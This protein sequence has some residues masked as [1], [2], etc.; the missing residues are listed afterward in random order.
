MVRNSLGTE[1]NFHSMASALFFFAWWKKTFE[2]VPML[3]EASLIDRHQVDWSQLKC[4][5]YIL[6]SSV[7]SD[8]ALRKSCTASNKTKGKHLEESKK[9]AKTTVTSKHIPS[10]L[11]LW[12]KNTVNVTIS[13]TCDKVVEIKA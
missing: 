13:V 11:T 9:I 12:R 7:I 1:S 10:T 4:V 6:K 2:T 5:G 8:E 3:K